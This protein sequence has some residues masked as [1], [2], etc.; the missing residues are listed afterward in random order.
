M[1]RFSGVSCGVSWALIQ[2]QV[3][4]A[5][6]ERGDTGVMQIKGLRGVLHRSAGL[7]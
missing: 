5:V 1:A 6:I 4:A 3:S 7:T 2:M